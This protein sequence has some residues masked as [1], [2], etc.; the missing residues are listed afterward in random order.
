[1]PVDDII[2]GMTLKSAAFAAV[3]SAWALVG[4]GEQTPPATSTTPS[5]S[6]TAPTE[7]PKT[8]TPKTE[9]PKTEE[10]KTAQANPPTETP[11]EQPK[12]PEGNADSQGLPK[13]PKA[14]DDVA[15]IDTAK[16]KIVVMFF[17]DKAP[18]T[19]E[20]FKTLAKKSFYN[21]TRFHRCIPGF[22]IQGGD[23]KSKDLAKAGE[24]GT[25]GNVVDGKEVNPPDE[26]NSIQHVKGILSMAHS[27]APNSA[28][29]QFFIVTS[30]S[31]F[32]DGQYTAFGKVLKGQ[33]VADEIVKTSDGSNNGSVEPSKAVVLKSV[34]IEKWP[35]K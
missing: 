18:K 33:D 31:T 30:D 26:F 14:G 32:L 34:K 22:M 28:S 25:G 11:K 15:V 20:N 8:E 5:S 10:A 7:T 17:P 9:A 1:M 24:W 21:G 13:E 3:L 19:V 4:C 16:G 2:T 23:P 6:T 12:M 29:S 27:A 35:V